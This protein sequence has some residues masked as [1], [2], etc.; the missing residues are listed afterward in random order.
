MKSKMVGAGVIALAAVMLA[1]CSKQSAPIADQSQSGDGTPTQEA[2]PV[3]EP[4]KASGGAGEKLGGA[5]EWIAGLASGKQMACQY[6]IPAGE[7]KASLTMKMYADKDRYKTEMDLPT[8]SVVSI[9]DGKTMYNWTKGT[10]QGMKMDIECAKSLGDNLPKADVSGRPSPQ[11]YDSPEQ[12]IGNIPNIT[13]AEA[14]GEVDLSVPS[15]V[16]FTDQCEM[17]K[18]TLGKMKD[19]QGKL[20]DSVKG[21]LP[22]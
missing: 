11:T 22:Q 3:S 14:S 6:V 5:A 13:C 4:T 19:M 9:F 17:L 7:G 21:A 1:G 8:G 18:S 10:K 12:A 16:T 20:P 2:S 15:D